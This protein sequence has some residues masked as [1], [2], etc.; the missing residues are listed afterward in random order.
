MEASKKLHKDNPY[1]TLVQKLDPV[2]YPK[3][4]GVMAA[5]IGYILGVTFIEP[6]IA[7]IAVTSDGF[8]LA[9]PDG[10]L[11]SPHFL[12]RYADL[13]HNWSRLMAAAGL[14]PTERIEAE[15]L[16][17]SRIGYFGGATA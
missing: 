14:T 1:Y 17:A 13:V 8:V 4:S 6:R 7:E 2:R 12:G 3:M 16:F 5:I 10:E 9:R 15:C 11:G